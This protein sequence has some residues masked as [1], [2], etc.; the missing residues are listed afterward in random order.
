MGIF[1]GFFADGVIDHFLICGMRIHLHAL[2]IDMAHAIGAGIPA[3]SDAIDVCIIK[4]QSALIGGDGDSSS[5]QGS[6]R[7]HA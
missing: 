6:Q 7:P 1:L 4:H 5:S 3:L 2:V